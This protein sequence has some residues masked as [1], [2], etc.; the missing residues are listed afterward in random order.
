M[1]V[2]VALAVAIV[3]AGGVAGCFH[4]NEAA[5]VPDSWEPLKVGERGSDQ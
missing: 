3:M 2:F 5:A 4:T 1:R